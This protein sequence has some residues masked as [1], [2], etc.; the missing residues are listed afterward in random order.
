MISLSRQDARRLAV[1][2]QLL[3]GPRPPATEAG[4][5]KVAKTLRSRDFEQTARRDW[6]SSGWTMGRNVNRM[7]EFL[8]VEGRLTVAGRAGQERL[9]DLSERWFPESTPRD[10]LETEARW[11]LIVEHALRAL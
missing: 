2:A 5:L 7:L 6:Q 1:N 4:L 10:G 9:W 11:D 3:A 8:W